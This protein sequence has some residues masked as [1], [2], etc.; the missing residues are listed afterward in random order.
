MDDFR[1]LEPEATSEAVRHNLE[2][3][4]DQSPTAMA[5][6]RRPRSH[7]G[8]APS[9]SLSDLSDEQLRGTFFTHAHNF[10]VSGGTFQSIKNMHI[11]HASPAEPSAFPTIPMGYLN[12]LHELL[13]NADTGVV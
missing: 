9:I 12:L 7:N 4:Y 1:Q 13:L 3:S 5:R 8:G 10:G 2:T 11:H 6:S